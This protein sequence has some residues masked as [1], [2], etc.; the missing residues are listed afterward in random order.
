[1][2]WSNKMPNNREPAL[3][4]PI[5][6]SL[7]PNT[8]LAIGGGDPMSHPGLHEFLQKEETPNTHGMH[9]QY[10]WKTLEETPCIE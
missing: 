5:L 6:D 1:M 8:E 10:T 7:Q 9:I 4:M 2:G 3:R